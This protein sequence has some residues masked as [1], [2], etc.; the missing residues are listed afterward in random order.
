MMAASGSTPRE[1]GLK[2]QS[3]SILMVT[4]RL[5]MRTAKNLMLSFSGQLLETVALFR[6]PWILGANLEAL[7]LLVSRLPVPEIDPERIRDGGRN[8]WKGFLWNDVAAKDVADFLTAYRTHPEAYRVN[9]ALLAE[10]IQSMVS[11]GELTKWTIAL[12]GG[13]QGA[14]LT[15][16]PGIAVAMLAEFRKGPLT[17]TQSGD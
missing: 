13:G 10:F 11:I 2:V 15:V 7:R 6:D 8:L 1:Y 9:S 12:I 5:K 4:S 14:E 16:A 3:H 17:G